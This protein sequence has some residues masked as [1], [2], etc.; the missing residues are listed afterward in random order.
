ML[1]SLK[2]RVA[3]AAAIV[4]ALGVAIATA[5]QSYLSRQAAFDAIVGQHQAYTARVA[6]D[7]D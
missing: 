5:L 3:L 7:I 1:H 2:G 6:A 4:I